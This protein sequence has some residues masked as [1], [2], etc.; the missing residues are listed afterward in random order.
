MSV[1]PDV[2][3]VVRRWVEK[4]EHDL[5]NAQYTLTLQDDCPFDTVCFHAQ[6][7][8][9]KYLKA[10]LI[11]HGIDSPRTHDLTELLPLLPPSVAAGVD[12]DGLAQLTPLGVSVRY[13]GLSPDPDRQE[14][15]RA[16]EIARR[17]R[18]AVR[19]SLPLELPG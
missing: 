19:G 8:A 2:A 16:V 1:P 9:E 3:E 18:A 6:Q 12:A 13:P 15:M 17:V 14:A 5:R 10:L 11:F 4:A 7:C